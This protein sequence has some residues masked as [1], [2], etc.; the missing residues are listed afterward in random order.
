MLDES[1]LLGK[2]VTTVIIS[3]L[4]WMGYSTYQLSLSQVEISA[5]LRGV[6]ELIVTMQTSYMTK[7]V[8]ETRFSILETELNR[9]RD[10]MR[11]YENSN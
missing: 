8:A 4:L 1:T 9:L 2:I 7:E 11:E 3:L 6:K 5:E 10:R